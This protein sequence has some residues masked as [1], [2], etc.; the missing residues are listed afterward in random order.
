MDDETR[1][2]A[3][4]EE[5][6][7]VILKRASLDITGAYGDLMKF[8]GKLGNYPQR[9]SITDLRVESGSPNSDKLSCGMIIT[10][11]VVEDKETITDE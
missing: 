3:Y 5:S 6:S 7:P 8:L 2:G 4:K 9:V 10:I 1:Q 11:Y